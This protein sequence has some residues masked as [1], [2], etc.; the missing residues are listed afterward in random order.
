MMG[1]EIKNRTQ[2]KLEFS[3]LGSAMPKLIIKAKRM[4]KNNGGY[5]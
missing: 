3:S 5:R 2:L 1:K 4:E